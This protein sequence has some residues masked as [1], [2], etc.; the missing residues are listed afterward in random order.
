MSYSRWSN[1]V[2]YTFWTA[3]PGTKT[4]FKLPTKKLKDSQM[5]EICDFPSYYVTYGYIKKKGLDQILKYI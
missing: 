1:S 5:F 2:W 3:Y 4:E